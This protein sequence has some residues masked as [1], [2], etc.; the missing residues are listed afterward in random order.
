[1]PELRRL[2]VRLSP[3]PFDCDDQLRL[4]ELVRIARRPRLPRPFSGSCPA[5][6][7]RAH[8]TTAPTTAASRHP[9][10]IYQPTLAKKNPAFAGCRSLACVWR[11]VVLVVIRWCAVSGEPGGSC[12]IHAFFRLSLD[13]V[14]LPGVCR[15]W[16]LEKQHSCQTGPVRRSGPAQRPGGYPNV[17]QCT[18]SI[19]RVARSPPARQSLEALCR[20]SRQPSVKILDTFQGAL[21]GGSA[22]RSETSI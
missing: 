6:R 17:M 7:P 12:P 1:M 15:C 9:P 21:S 2:E 11:S 18:L 10:D 4:T 5:A 8:R 13:V 16:L 3:R 19:R 22:T 14:F 20:C